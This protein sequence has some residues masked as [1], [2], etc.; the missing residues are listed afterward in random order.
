LEKYDP[1]LEQRVWKRVRGEEQ[2]PPAGLQ[3][4]AAAELNEAG[5]YLMLSRQLQGREK[6]LLRRLFAEEQCHAAVLRGM[7]KLM[8]GQALTTRTPPA[9]PDTPELALR[10]SYGRKLKALAEYESRAADK[11]YGPVFRKMAEQEREHCAL[12][13]EILGDLQR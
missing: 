12:L 6:A 5:A 11:E 4:L 7:H 3:A 10:K 13:L 8:T 2:A 1:E 9:P